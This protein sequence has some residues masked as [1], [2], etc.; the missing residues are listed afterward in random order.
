LLC[1]TYEI[2]KIRCPVK[3]A[4]FDSIY[5][6]TLVFPQRE[7]SSMSKDQPP[8]SEGDA[9]AQIELVHNV[10]A[11]FEQRADHELADAALA[12]AWEQFYLMFLGDGNQL[13]ACRNALAGTATGKG[14]QENLEAERESNQVPQTRPAR[15]AAGHCRPSHGRTVRQEAAIMVVNKNLLWNSGTPPALSSVL[16]DGGL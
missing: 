14:S 8:S 10:Q 13:P 1:A 16:L 7:G 12:Q 3:P 5:R 11:Y 15:K 2:L 4:D 6:G 9:Q